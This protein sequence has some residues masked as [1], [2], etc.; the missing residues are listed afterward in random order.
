[1]IIT[2]TPLRISFFGGGTDYPA[3]FEE[4]GGAVLSTT[5]D[6]YLYLHCRYLPPFFDFKSRIVWSK[7]ELVQQPSE[8]AHPAIR[9]VLKW[10]EISEGVEIHHHGDLPARTGLGSSSAFTVGLLHALHALRGDLVSKRT[11]AEQAIFVEQQVLRENVGVQDQIAAT[12]GGLNRID[13]RP[14][15][16]FEV[17]PVVVPGNR[18]AELQ[19]HLLL[20]YTGL[21]RI[22]SEIA[23]E[24]LVTM[25]QREGELKAMRAMVDEGQAILAGKGP[26][27]EFGR[28]LHESWELK[29]TLSSKVAPPLVNQVYDSARKA[30]AT[31]GKLL[32]AGG[33]GFI[34]LFVEP[35]R[36]RAVV[37]ALD[38]F[39][40][41]P[42]QF[43]RGGTQLVLYE[44]ET[45]DGHWLQARRDNVKS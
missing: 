45:Q 21:S 12:F 36:R 32:G 15:R 5:I 33:G 17:A 6:K 11:L 35:E 31:G 29:R 41:V 30:G 18:L 24:H 44:A 42:F 1:M 20:V 23:A 4:H 19:K 9:G 43:E 38:K 13:I 37:E 7:I 34:L 10:M 2:R 22:A 14:D 26:L 3:W 28:L 8:I 27:V 16:S 25:K 39:L 40:A